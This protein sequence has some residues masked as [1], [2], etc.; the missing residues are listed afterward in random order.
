MGTVKEI[1]KE[2]KKDLAII[3]SLI[4]VGSTGA[5]VAGYSDFVP[6]TKGNVYQVNEINRELS[7]ISVERVIGDDQFRDYVENLVDERDKIE[8]S[9]AFSEEVKKDADRDRR[10]KILGFGLLGLSAVG[11]VGY[12]R[13]KKREAEEYRAQR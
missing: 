1:F 6:P 4:T 13:Y 9:Q 8:S 7:E 10:N 5:F 11:G 3:A 2:A 12:S